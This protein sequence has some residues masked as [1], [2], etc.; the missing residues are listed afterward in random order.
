MT[1]RILRV[2]V[3]TYTAD[4]KYSLLSRGNLMQEIQ[5]YLSQKRKACS[6]FFCAFLKSISNFEHF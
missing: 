1:W 5:M 6:Q 2:F 4:D 3:D